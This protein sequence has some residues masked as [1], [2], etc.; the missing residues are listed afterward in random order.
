MDHE[1]RLA[2]LK[3]AMEV[4][5][6]DEEIIKRAAAFYEFVTGRDNL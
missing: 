6:P 4:G 5:G 3:L 2:C 1:I